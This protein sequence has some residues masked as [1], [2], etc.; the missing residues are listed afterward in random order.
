MV[1]PSPYQLLRGFLECSL[2]GPNILIRLGLATGVVLARSAD[3]GVVALALTAVTVAIL[4]TTRVH[5]L[6]LMGAGAVL[7]LAGLV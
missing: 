2:S 4:M 7:G 3:H 1:E 5:P 6:L